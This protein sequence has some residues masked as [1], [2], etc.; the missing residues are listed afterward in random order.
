[1][2]VGGRIRWAR[3]RKNLS[4]DQLAA[5]VGS[6]RSYLIR[7]EKGIH[8]PSLELRARIAVA[9]DQPADL[10][11]SGDEDE[12]EAELARDLIQVLRRLVAREKELV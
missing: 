10:F 2:P 9:T 5:Q 8:M 11:N 7:V 12:E 3:A 1:L 4:H 6:S